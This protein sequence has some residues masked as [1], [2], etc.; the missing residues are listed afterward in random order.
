MITVSGR[1]MHASV[2]RSEAGD[3]PTQSAFQ[4]SERARRLRDLVEQ[5]YDFVWRALRRL[6]LAPADTDDAAQRVFLIASRRLV[7]IREGSERG[8]LYRAAL[9]VASNC[10]RT[11]RRRRES[12]LPESTSVDSFPDPCPCT[13]ELVALRRA[14]EDLDR[15]LDAMPMELRAV[16]VLHELD[17]ITMAEIASMLELAPGTVASRLRRARHL[18]F[19]HVASL[20]QGS[21]CGGLTP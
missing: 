5:H 12:D 1:H 6:G 13:E 16:F 7:A 14:R 21:H 8:F 3:A 19:D 4:L 15:I 11:E 10:R 20:R 9:R 18:F 17:Q 2:I